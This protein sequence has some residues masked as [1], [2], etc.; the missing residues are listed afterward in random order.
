[1]D[2][3]ERVVLTCRLE[4]ESEEGNPAIDKF[5]FL[6]E[7]TVFAETENM[8]SP[9][10]AFV[11]SSINQAV[12]YTCQS[13]NTPKIGPQLSEESAARELIILGKTRC[14]YYIKTKNKINVLKLLTKQN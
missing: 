2:V 7:S 3:E 9:E 12:S 1:M 13:G 5:V 6:R 11:V 4:K 10:M 8:E 14:F